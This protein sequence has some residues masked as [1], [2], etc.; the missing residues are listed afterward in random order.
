MI[1]DM[2]LGIVVNVLGV[3]IFVLVIIYHF[4]IANQKKVKSN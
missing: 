1:T 4:I 2:Q 3:S